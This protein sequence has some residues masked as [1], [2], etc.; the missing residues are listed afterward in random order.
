MSLSQRTKDV[1]VVAMADKKAAT[2]LS[3]AVD[4]LHAVAP[5]A[6]VV[7]TTTAGAVTIAL[8]T[9]NTYTDAA[10]NTAVNTALA[11]LITDINADRTTI[12]QILT[13]LKNAGLML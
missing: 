6:D 3:K 10:V 8:S 7:A 13:A 12:N 9:A 4:S 5:A 2:E 11:S 1:L